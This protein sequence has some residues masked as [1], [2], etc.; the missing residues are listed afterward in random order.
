MKIAY[1][2]D[3]TGRFPP[4]G[5]DIVVNP[6]TIPSARILHALSFEI[7]TPTPGKNPHVDA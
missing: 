3:I 4:W 5:D 1:I 7:A 6:P 2:A